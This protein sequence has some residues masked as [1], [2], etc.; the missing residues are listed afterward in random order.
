MLCAYKKIDNKII[1]KRRV[2]G[3]IPKE[4]VNQTYPIV[5]CD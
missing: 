5:M 1:N 4:R 2:G 3:C